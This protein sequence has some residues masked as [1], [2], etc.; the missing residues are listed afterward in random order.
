MKSFSGDTELARRTKE[1]T[2]VTRNKLLDAAECLFQAQ[3][4]SRTTLQHIALRAGATRGAVY[5]HFK[6]K[7]DLFNAMM[8]RVTLP[9]EASFS[10][11]DTSVPGS[12]EAAGNA[13]QRILQCTQGALRQ[14]VT[15]AQTRRVFEVATH[16]VEYVEELQAVRLRHITVRNGFLSRIEQ[17]IEAA[18]QQTGQPLP[19]SASVAAQ[20]LHALI[21]GIIQN[22]L[23]NPQNFDLLKVGTSSIGIYL[24]GLG[25]R[26]EQQG[27]ATAEKDP[28]ST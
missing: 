13:L 1:E 8:E 22:W 21:D 10:L 18:S 7:A 12:G 9:M 20:G 25:F 26:A 2:L 27:L 15:D 11:E 16:K 24:S 17:S 19:V 23:L 5:W 3:G 28:L 14:I 6:D 4:V